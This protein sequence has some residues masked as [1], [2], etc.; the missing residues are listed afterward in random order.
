MKSGVF[1]SVLL[2]IGIK[3]KIGLPKVTKMRG[4]CTQKKKEEKGEAKMAKYLM[5]F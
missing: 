3:M 4:M 5:V 1:L 2:N